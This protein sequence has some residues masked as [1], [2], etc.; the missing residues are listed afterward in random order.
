MENFQGKLQS[1]RGYGES[2]LVEGDSLGLKLGLV[3]GEALGEAL[4]DEVTVA[5]FLRFQVG[6]SF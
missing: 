5:K 2:P 4:G 3:E 1:G 6:E